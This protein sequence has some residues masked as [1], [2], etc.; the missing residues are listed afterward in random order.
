MS[1]IKIGRLRGGFCVYWT[2]PS[3]GRTRHQLNARTREEA[4][5]EAIDVY[6]A[7]NPA[8]TGQVIR[9]I[10]SDYL[11]ELEGRPV[12]KTMSYTGKAILPHFGALRPDQ[13]KTEHCRSYTEKRRTG[14]IQDGSIWTELGHLRAV[15]NWAQKT[16]RIEHAPFIER[17]Q[18]PAPKERYLSR[19]EIDHLLSAPCEPHIKLAMLLML[20]TAGRVSAILELTWDR[21]DMERGLI[22][23][24][25]SESTTRK[26][27]AIVPMNAGLRAAL[28]K[29]REAA[30]SDHVIE[31]AG[32]PVK[33]IRKGIV[34]VAKRA[35]VP[36]V[37]PHVF[38][39]TSA[40][41]MAEAGVPMSEISQYLGH[42]N[43]MITERV[44]ARFSPDHLRKAAEV[45]D[46]TK[47][48]T[49]RRTAS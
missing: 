31:W 36:E 17:P 15:L 13:V 46:F 28:Q 25:T 29:A 30:L 8:P 9:R 6:R 1:N 21:V 3:G 32:G 5:A 16:R 14:G 18:K 4:E 34:N 7:K 39:H 19:E 10:W 44:Y 35:G 11:A 37:S 24:R 26:G 45:V 47:L 27:R 23:L 33:S 48:R 40:V 2:T 49:A 42:S 20:S 38:R 43:V 22:N 12:A 41:H